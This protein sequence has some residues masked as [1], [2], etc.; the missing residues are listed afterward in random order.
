[1]TRKR[2]DPDS[3][4]AIARRLRALRRLLADSQ[5]EFAEELGIPKNTWAGYESG[6]SRI[7]I[8]SALELYRRWQVDP[9]WVYLGIESGMILDREIMRRLKALLAE[10]EEEPGQNNSHAA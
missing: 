3:L 8:D 5:R 2:I 6:K 1:M 7:P 10:E 9:K 4:P